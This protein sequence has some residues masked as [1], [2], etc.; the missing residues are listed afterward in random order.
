MLGPPK[1]APYGIPIVLWLLGFFILI[2]FDGRGKLST[3]MAIL[4][5]VYVLLLSAFLIGTFVYNL[6]VYPN[7]YRKCVASGEEARDRP[8]RSRY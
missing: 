3:V 4:S 5:V 1:K 7:K 8:A 2:A 6:F